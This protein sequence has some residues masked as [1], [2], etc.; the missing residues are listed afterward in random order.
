MRD[1]AA[2]TGNVDSSL[3]PDSIA[4]ALAGLARGLEE[5]LSTQ[6]TLDRIVHAA[7]EL[8]PGT[9][10]ASII[11]VAARRAVRPQA[12]SAVM[13]ARI[14]AVQTETGE[15]P[16]LDS[17]YEQRTV[18]VPDMRHET[19][20]PHF[21]ARAAELGAGSMLSFQLYVTGDNLGALNLFASEPH[22]FT[23]QSVAV[24]TLFASHAAVAFA[25][26]RMQQQLSEAVRTGD[27][28]NTQLS[29]LSTELSRSNTELSRS[30]EDLR[31]FAH[32]ASHDLQAPLRTVGGFAEILALSL[33]H[34][35]L[36]A[37]QQTLVEAILGGVADMHRLIKDLLEYGRLG[38][39]EPE[40]ISVWACHEE[41][42]A[43][44]DSDIADSGARVQ[45]DGH[46]QMVLADPGQ[47]RQLLL[48]LIENS[49]RYRHPQR[50]PVV[51]TRADADDDG[52]VRVEVSDNGIGISPEHHE[53]IFTMFHTLR[54]ST[55]TGIGLA[56]VA[57]IVELHGG[58][59]DV[60][61]DGETGTTLRVHFPGP[62]EPQPADDTVDLTTK[63]DDERARRAR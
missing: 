45:T 40:L 49:I 51:T 35:N 7:I 41:V 5:E 2:H 53:R 54:K 9:E 57:R 1:L 47:L 43:M 39:P 29:E 52:N 42:V 36:T 33:G 10:Q 11:I 18:S 25:G 19:R 8:I 30:N 22:A 62:S 24:G 12:A 58:T 63:A 21:A 44:L 37:E 46:D 50:D 56:I 4:V 48:N 26:V 20:W 23:E 28:R 55:G 34:E 59:I 27:E 17:I 3:L 60:D 61:S 13:A 31:L 15:G 14:D 38:S 16:C 6:Q 32:V